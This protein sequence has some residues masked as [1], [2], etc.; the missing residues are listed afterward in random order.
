MD[1]GA[2]VDGLPELADRLTRARDGILDLTDVNRDIADTVAGNTSTVPRATGA[3]AGSRTITVT[4]Q[5]WGIA[6]V[7]PYAVPVH[8]GTR[9][10]TA[11][12]WLVQAA[13]DT[14]QLGMLADHVQHLL[15][16]ENNA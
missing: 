2:S 14:D 6:Y 5:G 8:W 3:L 7:K 1:L 10:M 13:K 11:R 12:P 16:G 4:S 15:N 9:Y